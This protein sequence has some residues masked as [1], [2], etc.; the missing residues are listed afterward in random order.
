MEFFGIEVKSGQLFD[1]KLGGARYLHLD[2]ASLG[3]TDETQEPVI[4]YIHVNGKKLVFATLDPELLPTDLFNLSFYKD[5]QI[6]HNLKNGS[7]Y[8]FGIKPKQLI[9]YSESNAD[10]HDDEEEETPKKE[11]ANKVEEARPITEY[12]EGSLG[13]YT[14][15]TTEECMDI[16]TRFPGYEE[17]SLG[18]LQALHV[19]LKKPA[20]ENFMV[21]KTPAIRMEFLKMMI[22]K[23][24]EEGSI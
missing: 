11:E 12:E 4:I 23:E 20:R 19:F 8:I 13:Y 3:Q 14:S 7:V 18:Y 16:V 10:R 5:F 22:E 2:Q 24:Y 1:V 15:P 21:P 6:S 17:G 9:T